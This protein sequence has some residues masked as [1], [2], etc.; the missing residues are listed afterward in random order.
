VLQNTIPGFGIAPDD[1]FLNIRPLWPIAQLVMMAHLVAG[2][3]VVLGGRF[4][5]ETFADQFERSGTTRSSLVPTQLI[6][7]LPHLRPGDPRL[8]RLRAITI[9]G[10]RV[11]PADFSMAWERLGPRI[12]VLYGLT[13]A[14]ISA[15][16]HPSALDA[17]PEEREAAAETVGRELFGAEIRLATATGPSAAA[18]AE[19]EVLIRGAHVMAGYWRDE[20]TTAAALTEGWLR[21]GDIGRFDEA[22]RLVITGRLKEVIRSG[23]S[24]IVPAEVED[25]I[26]SHPAVAEVAVVGLPDREWGEVVAAFIVVCPGASLDGEAVI[27]HCRD[28]L[29]P[30][31]KPR[32]V[33]F[34]TSIPRS[35]YGKVLR[36]E[37]VSGAVA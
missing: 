6:R 32:Q 21:T 4:T 29:A 37:L 13:E 28:R 16:L 25:A 7:L 36:Q 17:V 5:A 14:P 11:R 34:V 8:S 3:P 15:H 19:G 12:G 9:G 24:S 35:H 27:A 26:A 10:S 23:A 18:G 30:H 33:R 31:K 20:A 2:C 22:G 1:V